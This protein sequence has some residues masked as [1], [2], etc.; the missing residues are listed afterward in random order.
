MQLAGFG[1]QDFVNIRQAQMSALDLNNV[2]CAVAIDIGDKNDIHPREKREVG[3]RLS[4]SVLK[5]GYGVSNIASIT[6]PMLSHVSVEGPHLKVSFVEGTAIGLH[7]NGTLGCTTC[8]NELPFEYQINDHWVR[9][10]SMVIQKDEVI[11]NGAGLA[12]RLRYNYEPYPEC[13]LASNFE[14]NIAGKLP[15]VPFET[16]VKQIS[17][18]D[19]DIWTES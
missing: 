6:G 11:L 8:C 13:S 16:Q 5:M 9:V 18:I 15:T 7:L 12:V 3:R 17:M 10:S 4:L 14:P 2:G 1:N 19:N